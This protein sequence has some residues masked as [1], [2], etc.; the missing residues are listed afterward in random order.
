MSAVP[1]E[2]G[3]P[4]IVD[5]YI[6]TSIVIAW[7]CNKNLNYAQ[8]QMMMTWWQGMNFIK[9]NTVRCGFDVSDVGSPP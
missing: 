2:G 1:G 9:R 5:C 4:H 7:T 3:K 8:M 6:A